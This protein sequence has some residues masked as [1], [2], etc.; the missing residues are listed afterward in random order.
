[1][2]NDSFP[3]PAIVGHNAAKHALLLLAVEPMLKGVLI[4]SVSGSGKSA[5]ARALKSVLPAAIESTEVPFK[6]LPLNIAED[7]LLGGLDLDLTLATGQG[8]G[9]PGLLAQA[10]RGV[11]LVEDINL[12]DGKLATHISAAL[13]S[14]IA[15]VEREGL[16]ETHPARFSLVGTFNPE[17]GGVASI[18]R[19]R[20]GLLVEC[21]S[22]SEAGDRAEITFRGFGFLEDPIA[23]KDQF[24]EETAEIREI[25]ADARHRLK[26]IQ[27]SREDIRRIAMT[28]LSFGVEGNLA[29]IVAVRAARAAAALAGRCVVTEDDLVTA[30]QFVI[31]PRAT[32]LPPL[33]P[34]REPEEFTDDE[35]SDATGETKS[36]DRPGDTIQD[37]II[38][39]L[40]AELPQEALIAKGRTGGSNLSGK[41]NK[42]ASYTHGRY[43]GSTSQPV[44][45]ARVAIDATIRSAAPHQ[46]SRRQ[47]RR[48]SRLKITVDDLRFKR[49]KRR[50]G[51]LFI[52]VVDASGSMALNRMAQAKGALTRLLQNAYRRRD[53]VSLIALR[54]EGADLL[55]AP[56][57]SVELGKRAIAAMPVGGA[58]PLAAGL[59]KAL[60]VARDARAR[61]NSEVTVLLFTDGRANVSLR[62]QEP[63]D[64]V[65]RGRM[66]SDELRELGVALE[67]ER[68]SSIVID[69]KSRFVSGGE[70]RAL[71][72]LLGGRYL[73]LPRPNEDTIYE[74]ITRL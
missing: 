24:S 25:I 27:I 1:M 60:D 50:S 2:T 23:F 44:G 56:T 73:Y 40:D 20:I 36:K 14:G 41:G 35:A 72:D 67:R 4:S 30:I 11:L 65:S 70:G 37:L 39:A 18:L 12:L 10:D 45:R 7:R 3:F 32:T 21:T 49:F 53:R 22:I 55:L 6:I 69:T 57:R 48:G 15:R 71:A 74:A 33:D 66:I 64:T 54:G 29:D 46:L 59:V 63:G 19:D 42:R 17:E 68:V 26:E 47:G 51:T 16:S 58:T 9:S 5:L 62:T 31:L 61:D 43:A 8:R 13:E 38:L 34:V 28:S 52:L